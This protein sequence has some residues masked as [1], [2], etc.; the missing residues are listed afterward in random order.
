M[1]KLINIPTDRKDA[2]V[3]AAID[4]GVLCVV[5][6]GA[7]DGWKTLKA[8]MVEGA[9]GD[10]VVL[11][12][13][14]RDQTDIGNELFS[15]Q[16]LGISF[17]RGHKKCMFASIVLDRKAIS[18]HG[19][20]D[21]GSSLRIEAQWPQ[22]LQELQRRVYYRV[23][24]PG[25]KVRVRFWAGGVSAR[26]GDDAD[27]VKAYTGTLL[28]VSAGGMRI[29]TTD[30]APDTFMEGEPIGC[31][32]VPKPRAETIVLDAVFRHFQREDDGQY[33]VGLQF[34]GLETTDRGRGI[35]ASLAGV[36]TDYQREQARLE[37][38]QL[39]GPPPRR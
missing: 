2:I 21:S 20:P 18:D 12:A 10:R 30:V 29:Y 15:G 28:D 25:R 3:Q 14:S 36:V 8:K 26:A 13:E 5:T 11:C 17:R 37:R 19:S 4:K 39:A 22:L 16:R 32:F 27:K 24:P 35:L 33:S 23:C 31:S 7:P 34:V 38:R 9:P 6:Y 1:E